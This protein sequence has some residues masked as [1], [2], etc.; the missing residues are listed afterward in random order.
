M[1]RGCAPRSSEMPVNSSHVNSIPT[2]PHRSPNTGGNLSLRVHARAAIPL[3]PCVGPHIGT[4]MF[5]C[6]HSKTLRCSVL[7]ESSTP[8][9]IVFAPDFPTSHYDLPDRVPE[10]PQRLSAAALKAHGPS[11][12]NLPERSALIAKTWPGDR[13]PNSIP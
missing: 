12:P 10:R 7:F 3:Q 11:L 8:G 5:Q 1:R 13:A 2:L 4:F 6:G 9:A